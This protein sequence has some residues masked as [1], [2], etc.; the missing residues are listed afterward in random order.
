[1]A[2]SINATNDPFLQPVMFAVQHRLRQPIALAVRVMTEGMEVSF[3][4]K[5]GGST[6]II[7]QREQFTRVPP[8]RDQ[9]IGPGAGSGDG[10]YL[11][12]DV[13]EAAE[14]HLLAFELRAINQHGVE[15]LSRQP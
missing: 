13:N 14:Q 12:A 4:A 8:A 6:E 11:R 9:G 1:M 7:Y 2:R 3:D 15:K 10:E 5:A